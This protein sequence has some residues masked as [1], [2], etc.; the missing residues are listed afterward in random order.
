MS[1]YYLEIRSN[2]L[3]WG[4]DVYKVSDSPHNCDLL[5]GHVGEH[6][7]RLRCIETAT[8]IARRHREGPDIVALDVD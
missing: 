5:V 1:D 7:L 6:A 3:F 4:G 8:K 2:G